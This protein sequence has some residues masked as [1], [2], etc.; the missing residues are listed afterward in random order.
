MVTFP[1]SLQQLAQIYQLM[2]ADIFCMNDQTQSGITRGCEGTDLPLLKKSRK[3]LEMQ[4]IHW[5]TKQT[6]KQKKTAK[7]QAVVER[8]NKNQKGRGAGQCKQ[9]SPRVCSTAKV[10]S[11]HFLPK[12]QVTKGTNSGEMPLRTG[13]KRTI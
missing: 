9:P 6:N 11:S 13:M 12:G 1:Y 8:T 7:L 3:L 5:E 10:P 4:M 2:C